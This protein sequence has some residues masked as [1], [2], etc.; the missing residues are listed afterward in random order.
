MVISILR[1]HTSGKRHYHFLFP[2]LCTA[3]LHPCSFHLSPSLSTSY[4]ANWDRDLHSL[5][6][7][8]CGLTR[9]GLRLAGEGERAHN[10]ISSSL[11]Q[12]RPAFNFARYLPFLGP[13][14]TIKSFFPISVHYHEIVKASAKFPNIIFQA[15]IFLS[16]F[17][18]SM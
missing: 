17:D 2:P 10:I 16:Q 5:F 14:H 1:D 15:T 7:S 6:I 8:F 11:L 12:S 13:A 3:S 18:L 9:N 4:S